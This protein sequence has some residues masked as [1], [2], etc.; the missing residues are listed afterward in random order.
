MNKTRRQPQTAAVAAVTF[1][2][3]RAAI[4]HLQAAAHG[5][6]AS[7]RGPAVIARDI[8]GAAADRGPGRHA[9]TDP[10]ETP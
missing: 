10:K 3:D 6:R 1:H 4:T 7:R 5:R 9:R 2:S 8:L